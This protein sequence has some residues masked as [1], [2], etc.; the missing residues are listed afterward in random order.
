MAMSNNQM[1]CIYIYIITSL[2]HDILGLKLYVVD[3]SSSYK[4][5]G[6]HK[7]IFN[8]TQVA[9]DMLIIIIPATLPFQP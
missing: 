8:N 1:V 2:F 4:T 6:L 5:S 7:P 3:N 9:A